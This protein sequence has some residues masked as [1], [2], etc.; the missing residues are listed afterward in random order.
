MLP[1]YGSLQGVYRAVLDPGRPMPDVTSFSQRLRETESAWQDQIDAQ[2]GKVQ[3]LSQ[4][5]A[6]AKQRLAASAGELEAA[7]AQAGKLSGELA[8]L[9]GRYEELVR[10]EACFHADLAR[11][12][13]QA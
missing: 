3:G 10:A 6:Q 11:T 4:E 1:A 7:R 2:Q 5:L 13:N 8:A 12:L 9:R